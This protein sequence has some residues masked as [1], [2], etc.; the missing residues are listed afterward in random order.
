MA[1][2]FAALVGLIGV[3]AVRAQEPGPIASSP[4]TTKQNPAEPG[5]V[6]SAPNGAGQNAGQQNSRQAGAGQEPELQRAPN[7]ENG[8]AKAGQANAGQAAGGQ[9]KISVNV[10]TVSIQATVRD[11]HGKIVPNLTKD[12]FVV[13]EDGKAQTLNY[14]AKESDVPLRLGLL[15]DTSLS[16]RRVLDQERSASYAFLD[17]MVRAD[18]DLAFVVQFAREVELLQDFT[19]SKPKLQ[20][21]LQQL[22]TP[23]ME[24]GG[25]NGGGSNGGG[26]PNGGYGGS[27][28]GRGGYGGHGHGGGGTLL[29]DAVYLAGSELMSK[30]TGRKALII[31]SDGVDH[32][33]RETLVEAIRTA[34]QA[35]TVVYSILFKDDE[36]GYG[37]SPGYGGMH[38]G[39]HGGYGGPMGGGGGRYPQQ[40]ERPDGKKILKQI[41]EQTGGRLFEVTKK[42]TAEKIYA[43]IEEELRNQYSLGYT[44]E[45]NEGAGYHRL[46]VTTK[47]GEYK[48]QARD[49]Y[50]SAEEGQ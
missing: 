40:Q 16:Q 9:P 48:V 36:G 46:K 24:Q 19:Q 32:G 15:V 28:G 23:Q 33:S 18:K 45:K 44:P 5:P 31:L 8:A 42:E 22:Q 3:G 35:D 21:A 39:H 41:S 6:T 14:F 38:G 20:A 26:G 27:G 13:E 2:L 7:A 12:D 11:K 4:G 47:N 25:Q 50:Y 1:A 34:Q 17:D 10:K 37:G 30:Q 49:G 29:Y 43:E